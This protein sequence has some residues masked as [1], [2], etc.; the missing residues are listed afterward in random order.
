MAAS[1]CPWTIDTG[2]DATFWATLDPTI[3]ARATAFATDVLWASTGRQFSACTITVRP[4]MQSWGNWGWWYNNGYFLD[5]GGGGWVPFNWNGQWYNGCGCGNAGPFCCEPRWNTQ[6]LLLGPVASIQAVT[7]NGTILDPTT[8]RVDDGQWLVRTDGQTWP[9]YQD[10]NADAG[11]ANTWT[12][13]YLR[14]TQVPDA[15]LAAAGSLA[16]QYAMAC[17][18]NSACRLNG[19]VTSIIRQGV[20]MTLVDPTTL[21]KMGLTGLEEV[22]L[23][24]RSYNPTGLTHRLRLY[25]PDVEYNRVTTWQS[26]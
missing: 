22:D 20:Q 12:V 26:S 3:Q 13:E 21:L 6:V 19:R 16:I 1:T 18:G 23:L 5:G 14:G 9:I 4:C 10:L 24:I 15:L 11:A 17:T 8:Y 25:S 2:C 7:V